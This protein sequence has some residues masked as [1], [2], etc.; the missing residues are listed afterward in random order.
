MPY[1]PK[2]RDEFQN[3][4]EVCPDCKV[5]LIEE[6]PPQPKREEHDEPL[7]HIATAPNEPLANMWSGILEE[8]DIRCSLKSRNITPYYVTYWPYEIY[9]LSSEAERAKEMLDPFLEVE[10]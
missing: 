5:A 10:G 8:N 1:C 4:I 9:V 2:C 3:W 7:V 6:L